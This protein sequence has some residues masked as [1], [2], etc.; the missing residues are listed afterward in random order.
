MRL[1]VVSDVHGATDALARAGDGAD[2]LLCLGDLV[3]FVDYDDHSQRHLRRHVRRATT[4]SSSSRCAPP[5]ASTRRASTATA[6]WRTVEGD[7]RDILDEAVQPAVRRAVRRDADARVPDLRQRRRPAAV[8][9]AT[10]AR[11]STRSTA[12][13]SRS[14]ASASGSSA[15]GCGRPMR[16]PYEIS[17]EEYAAK[18]DALGE[19]DVLCSHIPPAVPELT[20]DVVARRFERGSAALLERSSAP[21]RGSCCSGTCT[22]RCAARTRDRPHRVR[23]RRPL[24]VDRPSRSSWSGEAAVTAWLSAPRR[25]I[26]DRRRRRRRSW[27]SSPTSPRYPEWA[28]GITDGRGARDRRRTAGPRRARF[29]L[30]AGPVRDEYVLA[31]AWDDRRGHAGRLVEAEVLTAMDGALRR[32]TPAGDGAEVAL[33]ADRR[34]ARCRCSG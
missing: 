5:A 23:Q 26:H 16:T 4:A 9:R 8:G 27:T 3:L 22:S 1:H 33:P 19:V 24:P 29:R 11:A 20:Y 13:S 31:Y 7:R 17:D 18:L 28:S 30:D 10:S 6:L 25:S 32:S 12:R 2:A 21:S 15:A 34:P 14:T